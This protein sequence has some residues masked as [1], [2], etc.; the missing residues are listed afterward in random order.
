MPQ[1]LSS[2]LTHLSFVYFPSRDTLQQANDRLLQILSDTVKANLVSEERINRRLA[3]LV[4]EGGRL[5]SASGTSHRESGVGSDRPESS[6]LASGA[7][8]GKQIYYPPE[9]RR[10]EYWGWKYSWCNTSLLSRYE[11]YCII[12]AKELI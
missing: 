1:I 7:H 11:N 10:G 12:I 4:A 5:S 6:S 9:M 2:F 3:G 8:K